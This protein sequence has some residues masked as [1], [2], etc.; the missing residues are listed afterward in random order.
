MDKIILK[1]QNREELDHMIKRTI[2]L[3][4]DESVRVN[5]LKE[6]KKIMFFNIKGTYEVEIVRKSEIQGNK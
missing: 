5:V 1:A 4:E 3:S 2:T 6:P